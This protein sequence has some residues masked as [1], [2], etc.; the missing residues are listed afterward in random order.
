MSIAQEYKI[1]RS[2]KFNRSMA[3]CTHITYILS[4]SVKAI[5]KVLPMIYDDELSVGTMGFLAC[6]LALQGEIDRLIALLMATEVLTCGLVASV[7]HCQA[8]VYLAG[9][10]A[11][12]AMCGTSLLFFYRVHAVYKTSKK[13]RYIFCFLWMTT[14]GVSF[15]YPL[16]STS[17][18]SRLTS[19]P[20]NLLS[21]NV[22][23]RRCNLPAVSSH[24]TS[25][26]DRLKDASSHPCDH[27]P[28]S[29]LLPMLYITLSSFSQYP[30]ALCRLWPP[31]MAGELVRS[32][33]LLQTEFP[34][35]PRLFC[36][37][38]NYTTCDLQSHFLLT[39]F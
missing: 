9:S 21:T 36:K 34:E 17:G 13:I 12:P 38:D 26:S 27:T 19:I 6:T 20:S 2:S 33:S 37:A 8:L 1:I 25:T 18:V 16:A 39:I 15:L 24:L 10:F 28:L 23:T 5:I 7:E 4:R 11:I 31:E 35:C 22:I 29:L 30:T 14:L 32:R 3:A